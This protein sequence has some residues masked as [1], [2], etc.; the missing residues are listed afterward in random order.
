MA[1]TIDTCNF[2]CVHLGSKSM[3]EI[4]IDGA[5]SDTYKEEITNQVG[6]RHQQQRY[7]NSHLRILMNHVSSAAIAFIWFLVKR[8]CR[9]D[10]EL[11][12]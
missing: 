12:E 11:N 8:T 3:F 5:Q 9:D 6:H 2:G 7:M 10:L 1:V 4:R